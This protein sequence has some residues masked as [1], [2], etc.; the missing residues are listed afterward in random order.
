MTDWHEAS[1]R[2]MEALELA[3]RIIMENGGETYRVEETVTRMGAAFGLTRV[4]CFAVPSGV[5][6]SFPLADGGRETTVVRVRGS[7]TNLTRVDEINAISRRVEH[8]H[9]SPEESLTLL[10]ELQYRRPF[11]TGW[12]LVLAAAFSS[13]C[14]A[15][16][17]GGGP[18][19]F[20]TAFWTAGLVQLLSAVPERFSIGT[21]ASSLIG[22]FLSV[23]LP[24]LFTRFTGLGTVSPTAAGAMMPLLPGLRMTTAVQDVLRGDMVSGTSNGMLA[25]LVAALIAVGAIGASALCRFLPG[26]V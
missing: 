4:D 26:G 15:L 22:A 18:I 17:F 3:G 2:A 14:F 16:M 5:F 9:L 8:E 12:R 10:K 6:I 11:V 1:G 20:L 21:L 7:S 25:L 23:L 24:T 19:D 13:G